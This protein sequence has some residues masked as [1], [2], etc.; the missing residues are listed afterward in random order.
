MAPRDNEEALDLGAATMEGEGF[1]CH[2]EFRRAKVARRRAAAAAS[3]S[4]PPL[5]ERPI[6]FANVR[7]VDPLSPPAP[8]APCVDVHVLGGVVTAI[9]TTTATTATTA[10]TPTSGDNPA[11]PLPP[12]PPPPVRVDCSGLFLFPGLLDAHVHCTAV[13]ADLTALRSMPPT[14]M[15]PRAAAVLAGMLRRGFTAVR[16]CGGADWGLAAA[17]DEGTVLGPR[18][19]FS[20][21]ALSQT[22]GHGDMRPREEGGNGGGCPCACACAA[23]GI[24]RVCDGADS[25]RLA[26]REELR[27]GASF[28]K[29][30]ASGGVSSPTDRLEHPQFSEEELRAACEEAGRKGCGV[31]C[32]AYSPLSISRAVACGARSIE[33]GNYLDAKCAEQMARAGCFLVP[34]LVTYWAIV[35]E[36]LVAGF[37]RALVEKASGVSEAGARSLGVARAAGVRICYGS[38]LL[39]PMHQHQSREFELRHQA[40]IEAGELLRQA[41][42]EC[43]ALLFGR[44]GGEQEAEEAQE[45]QRAAGFMCGRVLVGGAADFCLAASDPREDVRVLSQGATR[46]V[47]VVKEGLVA[48]APSAAFAFVNARAFAV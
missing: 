38:D 7:L 42:T 21:R 46:I 35:S 1:L 40:G 34:T 24:G 33:H 2:D 36:G 23:A 31:A 43:A 29:V 32:H 8:D 3:A 16:D 18:V 44:A 22:G 20:G 11:A 39:G 41:T 28:I 17:V 48:K 10:T 14:L 4:P 9:Q 25:V 45:Q 12:P 6:V 37:P 19:L 47:C 27:L 15:A 26:A 13:I 30:M 5:C